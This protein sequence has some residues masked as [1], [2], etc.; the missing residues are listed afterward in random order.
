MGMLFRAVYLP[1]PRPCLGHLRVHGCQAY[2]H[3]PEAKR[4]QKEKL[5]ECALIGHLVG[6]D[7]TNIF[8]HL[9][10]S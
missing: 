1:H 2:A 8:L 9:D 3:N 4:L 6:F 5:H 10:S 7:S